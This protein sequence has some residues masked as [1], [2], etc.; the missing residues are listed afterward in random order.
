MS[1]QPRVQL[2]IRH[3]EEKF[4][5]RHEHEWPLARTQWTKFYFE[6]QQRALVR[7]PIG[8]TARIDYE[9]M[10]AGVTFSMGPLRT[11]RSTRMTTFS[12]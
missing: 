11:V 7:E 9:A 5:E 2:L 12:C 8:T 4:V 3:P 10:S 6:A 1:K